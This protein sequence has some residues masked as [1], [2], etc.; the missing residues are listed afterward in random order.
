MKKRAKMR[1]SV[2]VFLG[3]GLVVVGCSLSSVG[4]EDPDAAADDDNPGGLGGESSGGGGTRASGGSAASEGGSSGRAEGGES[5]SDG[6]LGG[7]SANGGT[8][9]G[10]SDGG[11]GAGDAGAAGAPSDCIELG[12][13]EK[14]PPSPIAASATSTCFIASDQRI[15]CWGGEESSTGGPNPPGGPFTQLSGGN[16]SYCGLGASSTIACWGSYPPSSDDGFVEV[17]AWSSI[18]LGLR[19]DGTMQAWGDLVG[20]QA[21]SWKGPIDGTVRFKRVTAGSDTACGIHANGAATCWRSPHVSLAV[22]GKHAC[23]ANVDGTVQCWGD[24]ALSQA[25]PPATDN[26]V[27]VSAG[28]EHTCAIK[29]TGDIWCWGEN[30]HGEST[31]IP[32]TYNQITSGKG[33]SCGRDVPLD[34]VNCWGALPFPESAITHQDDTFAELAAGDRHV[35]Q[36]SRPVTCFGDDSQGQSSPPP[37]T[38]V[39]AIASGSAHTCGVL[40]GAGQSTPGSIRCWGENSDSQSTP[41]DGFF[42]DV[43]AGDFHTCALSATGQI[44]CWG[45]NDRGQA[46]APNDQFVAVG[47]GGSNSCGVSVTGKTHCWGDSAFGQLATPAPPTFKELALGGAGGEQSSVVCGIRSD[48]TRFCSNA[49]RTLATLPATGLHGFA[50]GDLYGNAVICALR[51]NNTTVC[52][53]DAGDSIFGDSRAIFSPPPDELDFVSVGSWHACGVRP[54]RTVVCWGMNHYGQTSVPPDLAG[55]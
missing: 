11:S 13:C 39:M 23:R 41:P 46:S 24:D 45:K 34:T 36:A 9:G 52:W 29:A 20:P 15:R 54:N 17:A 48:D 55:P 5:G 1:P 3:T 6:G 33:F 44:V 27:K 40:D 21:L 22:G 32:G 18:T 25:S 50:I 42:I 38:Y 47:A 51:P 7:S 14:P 12:N 35:C 16:A 37:N 28:A 43:A 10:S 26:F 19:A 8:A 2:R 31:P 30:A 4:S 49:K 53:G